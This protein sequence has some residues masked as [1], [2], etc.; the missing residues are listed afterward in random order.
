MLLL[1]REQVL[2]GLGD[3]FDKRSAE[4]FRTGSCRY[5]GREGVSLP[6]DKVG[7]P[8]VVCEMLVLATGQYL[9]QGAGEGY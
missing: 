6:S 7:A 8:P 4:F 1:R 3:G 2:D 9:A 5:S